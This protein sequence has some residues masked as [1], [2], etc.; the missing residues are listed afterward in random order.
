LPREAPK[1]WLAI[2]LSQTVRRT[3]ARIGL[4]WVAVVV[5]CA[6]F[7]PFLANSRP[8]LI[9]QN[10]AWS[11]PVIQSMNWADVALLLLTAIAITLFF[12][13]RILSG[14]WLAISTL[15]SIFIVPIVCYHVFPEQD[16][17]RLGRFRQMQASGELQ[18]VVWAPIRYSPEDHQRDSFDRNRPHPQKPSD[19][20][21]LGT[22]RIG[23]SVL[24]R[25]IHACRIALAVGFIA[26]GIAV[27]IGVIVG[28]LMGYF[29]GWVDLLGMRLVEIFSSIPSMY[30]L[31]TFVA[32]F[33]R[34]LYLIMV[35]IGITSW[36]GY[37]YFT[38][39]EFLRLRKQDFVLAAVASG[40]PTWRVLFTHILPNGL[41]P[42]LVSLSFGVAS[43]ILV[44][45]TLSFLGL[46]PEDTA[47]WGSLLN[48]AVAAGGGFYWWLATFPGI[49]IFL[50]VF[51]YNLI[52]EALR[53]TLDPRFQGRAR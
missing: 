26:E 45:S 49:A 35:I 42:V 51:S 17:A 14:R 4:A 52:G 16:N 47:S 3:G 24:S 32:F 9:K 1:F 25:M 19:A 43:A 30:L 12:L 29:A 11:S 5:F 15:G 33:G 27:V 20:N 44:E 38:R 48:Q 39:A 2:V 21:A 37:A 40:V 41:T 36:T 46:G 34:D 13:R 18:N 22:E 10:G 31:L 50:T 23:A 8:L 6:V 28:G 7:A 53:D